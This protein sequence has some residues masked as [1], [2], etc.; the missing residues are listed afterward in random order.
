MGSKNI[1]HVGICIA[2]HR[3]QFGYIAG[4]SECP[5]GGAQH[6]IVWQGLLAQ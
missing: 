4:A 1:E 5:I 2:E 6:C 3:I